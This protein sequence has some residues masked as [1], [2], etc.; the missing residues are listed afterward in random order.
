[1]SDVL[2]S[3]LLRSVSGLAMLGVGSFVILIPAL[4]LTMG[5]PLDGLREIDDDM[6]TRMVFGLIA[7]IGIVAMYL[8]SYSV[9]REFYYRSMSRTIVI[10]SLRRVF[11]AK[12]VSS[13]A[14]SIALGLAGAA[15]WAVVTGVVLTAHDRDL[16]PSAAFWGIVGGS[17]LAAG[18]GAVIGTSLGWVVQNYYAV[19]AIVLLVPTMI[20]LPLLFTVPD[21]ERFLPVGAFA[22]VTGAP[23]EGLLPWWASGVVLLVWAAGATVLAIMVVRRRE[24]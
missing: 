5:P 14:T 16:Q 17:M 11:V 8:G 24:R 2:K 22:G 15:V 3:E 12:L 9:S 4:I 7:S 19:S 21:V 13:V 10:G 6:A 23:I 1:M 18:C 20:E